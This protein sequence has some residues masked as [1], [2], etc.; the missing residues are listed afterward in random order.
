MTLDLIQDKPFQIYG[1][2]SLQPLMLA[3]QFAGYHLHDFI[4]RGGKVLDPEDHNSSGVLSMFRI[5]MRRPDDPPP[6]DPALA[7]LDAELAEA[8]RRCEDDEQR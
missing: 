2:G 1:D 4:E 6:P 8:K 3:L 7:E 5:L